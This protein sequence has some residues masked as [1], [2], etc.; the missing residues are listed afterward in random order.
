MQESGQGAA[1]SAGEPHGRE[2][3]PQARARSDFIGA[4]AWMAFGVAVA[5]GS[6]NMD[7][8]EKQDINPYTIPGLVPGLL[9]VAVVFFSLLMLARAWRQ[10][11]LTAMGNRGARAGGA[12]ERKRFAIVLALCLLLDVVLLGHGLP[13]WAAA[14]L[15][16][17]STIFILQYPE[18]KAAG[19]VLCGLIVAALIGVSAGIIITL[20][21]QE[22]FLV[23]LP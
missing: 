6:W 9:G 23:R 13:F 7:R 17:T 18:R 3:S 4:L 12:A 21:F 16:V 22:F 11:A 14:A 19:Q 10:G 1:A 2:A 15:Y 8:L 20:I 5:V